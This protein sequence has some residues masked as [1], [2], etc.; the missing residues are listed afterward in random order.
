MKIKFVDLPRQNSILKDKLMP[1][2]EKVYSEADF[3]MGP[4]LNKFES[5]FAKFCNKKYAIGVNSGTD[6]L[7]LSLMAYGINKG[8][9]VII[10][11]NSYFSTAM[12]VSNLEAKPI[13]VDINPDFYTID[14]KK[15]EKAITKKT[16]AIIPVH[17]YGQP[18]EMDKILQIAKKHKL[19][20][21]EDACQAH[22]AKYK[23][24]LI[25]YGETGAFSFFPGKNLG[26]FGDG[27]V[28]VTDNRKIA[29]KILYLRNDGSYKKYLHPMFG[30]KSRLDTLQAAVLS[31]KLPYLN[32]WNNLRRNNARKY[33]DLLK[34]I[35]QIKIPKENY[36]SYHVFHLYVIESE[37]R[38]KLQ[39]YLKDRG[40]E[41]IIHYPVPI[42]LQKPYRLQG[43]KKGMFPVTEEKS[44]RILSL[45]M[46][47]ELTE[48]EIEYVCKSISSFFTGKR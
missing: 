21:I 26:A 32:K 14:V 31:F 22:G 11:V 9:E 18:A 43:Y 27:G 15:I 2:I 23:D 19:T 34:L 45:P 5:E 1:V 6:A 7:M 4:K 41:T 38:D 35:P 36:D 3:T 24:K 20:I 17:L 8:D 42:H 39:Q 44:R 28:V 13:F 37:K 12:V 46:F 40:I 16:K 33:S 29:K 30:I 10:P 25:P 47:P 48:R